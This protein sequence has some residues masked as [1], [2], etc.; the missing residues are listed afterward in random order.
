MLSLI[1]VF[2]DV[3]LS[4]DEL[5][6][7]MEKTIRLL[8]DVPLDELPP[9]IFQLLLLAKQVPADQMMMAILLQ[10]TLFTKTSLARTRFIE[11]VLLGG[12]LW[13]P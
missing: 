11:L 8:P 4:G 2:R 3:A 6:L 7:V 5:R 13:V 10:Q 9:I 1:P 12:F